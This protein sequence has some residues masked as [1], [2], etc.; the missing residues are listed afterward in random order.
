MTYLFSNVFGRNVYIDIEYTENLVSD[1][2]I[3]YILTKMNI[4]WRQKCLDTNPEK[5]IIENEQIGW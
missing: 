1:I 3:K 4:A 2:L 5:K